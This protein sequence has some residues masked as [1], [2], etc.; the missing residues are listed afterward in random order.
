MK[1]ELGRELC[2]AKQWIASKLTENVGTQAP[3]S[4]HLVREY[5]VETLNPGIGIV[6]EFWRGHLIEERAFTL[7]PSEYRNQGHPTRIHFKT[8]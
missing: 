4:I 3:Q 6:A 2:L 7:V 5:K 8:T 1:R